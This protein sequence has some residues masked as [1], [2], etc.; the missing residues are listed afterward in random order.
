MNNR[1]DY[2]CVAANQIASGHIKV[3]KFEVMSLYGLK[4]EADLTQ[5]IYELPITAKTKKGCN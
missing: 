1:E 2:L 3:G 4:V 5:I